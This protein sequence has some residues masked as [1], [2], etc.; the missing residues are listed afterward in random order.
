VVDSPQRL[1]A[2]VLGWGAW[3]LCAWLSRE[4]TFDRPF[5]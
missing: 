5:A 1:A 4:L 2:G 3:A